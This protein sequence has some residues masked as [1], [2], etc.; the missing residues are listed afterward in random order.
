MPGGTGGVAVVLNSSASVTS[1]AFASFT[2][3]SV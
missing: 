3:F 1:G 2:T